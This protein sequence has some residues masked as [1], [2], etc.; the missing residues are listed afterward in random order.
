MGNQYEQ[1][2]KSFSFPQ[3]PTGSHGDHGRDRQRRRHQHGLQ[4]PHGQQGRQGRRR[5]RRRKSGWP[6]RYLVLLLWFSDTARMPKN[7]REKLMGQKF[8]DVGSELRWPDPVPAG[9]AAV[10]LTR[11]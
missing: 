7:P 3:S 1:K 10:G 8:V 2:Q 11:V 9:G 5:Q 4:G 6:D